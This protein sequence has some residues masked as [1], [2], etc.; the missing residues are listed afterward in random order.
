MASASSLQNPQIIQR[1]KIQNYL[2]QNL[3]SKLH[4]QSDRKEKAA[5]D[6]L[7]R[8]NLSARRNPAIGKTVN[9]VDNSHTGFGIDDRSI[10]TARAGTHAYGSP[11]N[12]GDNSCSHQDQSLR[13]DREPGQPTYG[14]APSYLSS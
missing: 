3:P 1:P 6:S 13:F 9:E 7:V 14:R 12:P 11:R 10:Y 8:K 2:T 5:Q 4:A